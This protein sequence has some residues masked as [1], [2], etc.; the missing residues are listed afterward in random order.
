M[1]KFDQK[2]EKKQITIFGQNHRFSNN[3]FWKYFHK[4]YEMDKKG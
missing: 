2:Y 1:D 4:Q 3:L